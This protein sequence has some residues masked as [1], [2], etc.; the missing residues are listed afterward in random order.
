MLPWNF[1]AL[2]CDFPAFWGLNWVQKS[3][4]YIQ[5]NAAFIQVPI[6]SH[7][8]YKKRTNVHLNED[9]FREISKETCE[10]LTEI[11]R[12]HNQSIT[13][14]QWAFTFSFR[15]YDMLFVY[16]IISTSCFFFRGEK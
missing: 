1:K 15:F 7:T 14:N 12:L 13:Q 2:K 4:F 5:E 6:I 16:D 8:T 10:E 3:V 11:Q 9:K